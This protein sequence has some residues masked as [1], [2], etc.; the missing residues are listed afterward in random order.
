MSR[1][2]RMGWEYRVVRRTFKHPD[3]DV[4]EFYGIHEVHHITVGDETKSGRTEDPVSVMSDSVD[5]LR[6]VLTE[7]LKALDK[8]V[9]EGGEIE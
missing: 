2:K 5:G 4:E 9:I 1:G 6:W 7:M 3:S 8:E